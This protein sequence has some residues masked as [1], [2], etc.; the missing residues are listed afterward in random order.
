MANNDLG[1]EQ[2]S[3]RPLESSPFERADQPEQE[4]GESLGA[5]EVAEAEP[6]QL[7]PRPVQAAETR[8][9]TEFL[10]EETETALAEEDRI[11]SEELALLEE[12]LSLEEEAEQSALDVDRLRRETNTSKAFLY[13]TI[14]LCL[15]PPLGIALLK[16]PIIAG[17]LEEGAASLPIP[18]AQK[19]LGRYAPYPVGKLVIAEFLIFAVPTIWYVMLILLFVVFAVTLATVSACQAGWAT[20]QIC[21]LIGW[22]NGADTSLLQ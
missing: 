3:F 22:W 5:L 2:E 10:E 7:A 11:A 8:I 6:Q 21:K 18:A 1:F 4:P 17:K 13:G 9:E 19:I 15:F 20:K 16:A 14:L 12:Q